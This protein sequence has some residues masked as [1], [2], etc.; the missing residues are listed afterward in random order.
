MTRWPRLI[1]V[2]GPPLMHETTTLRQGCRGLHSGRANHQ[3]SC[4]SPQRSIPT[5]YP[6]TRKASFSSLSSSSFSTFQRRPVHS[7]LKC[8]QTGSISSSTS[9]TSNSSKLQGSTS[10]CSG[11]RV[12]TSGGVGQL[13]AGV[14]SRGAGY[15]ETSTWQLPLR[16]AWR[17]FATPR[18]FRKQLLATSLRRSACCPPSSHALARRLVKRPRD[19]RRASTSVH[20]TSIPSSHPLAIASSSDLDPAA[21]PTCHSPAAFSV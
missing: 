17:G 3:V 14:E 12:D 6:S 9:S 19:S 8:T 20:P 16:G 18:P 5:T 7:S 4:S 2:D 13:K 1:A 15:C 11:W 10:V 21:R